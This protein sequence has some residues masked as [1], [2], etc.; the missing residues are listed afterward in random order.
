MQLMTTKNSKGQRALPPGIREHTA[1]DGV[2]RYQVR[3]RLGG[4]QSTSTVDTLR[5]AKALKANIDLVGVEQAL[6][7]VFGPPEPEQPTT[8]TVADW[9]E[10]YIDAL[11][12]G[13]PAPG[14]RSGRPPGDE[15][16][17]DYKQYLRCDIKPAAL[18][19][20]RLADLT[21][22]DVAAWMKKLAAKNSDKTIVNKR[23]PL[24]GALDYAVQKELIRSN[25]ATKLMPA[26]TFTEDDEDREMI[27]L[28][29]VEFEHVLAAM[30][31]HYRHFVQFLVDSG[32]R[33]NE[34][35]ALRPR[36]I[37]RTLAMVTFNKTFR[38]GQSSGKG[39]HIGV[40]KTPR[41]K[42]TIAVRRELLDML[43]FHDADDYVFRNTDGGP[44]RVGTFRTNI[45]YKRMHKSG[46]PEH[47]QPRIHDLRH[48]HVSWLIADGWDILKISRRLGHANPQI[49]LNT[50]G[51]L[52]HQDDPAVEQAAL[53]RALS[54]PVVRDFRVIEGG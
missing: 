35:T 20:I 39:H 38:R 29:H 33:V 4:K 52:I 43:D 14:S 50:Y 9:V 28:N 42:R 3:Y 12:N 47:R 11:A 5:E 40:P 1:A 34:A 32:C 23:I 13:M 27:A 46:L 37:D 2:T 25:P 18:G 21:R 30:P 15:A 26:R 10:T 7:E 41:S 8:P 36:N 24:M 19:S 16:I 22:E 53:E 45:W 6:R 49:T 51:H 54:R 48:T 44:I 31:E 17:G